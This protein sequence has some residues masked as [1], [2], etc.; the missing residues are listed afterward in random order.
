[1]QAFSTPSAHAY[2]TVRGRPINTRAGNSYD[3]KRGGSLALRSFEVA[4]AAPRI[5]L[6]R[7]NLMIKLRIAFG[8]LA[9]AALLAA[10]GE[11]V[12]PQDQ[13]PKAGSTTS[14]VA[15]APP[16]QPDRNTPPAPPPATHNETPKEPAAAA[17]A[18]TARDTPAQKP[19]S[20][21]TPS[22]ESRSMPKPMQTDNHSTPSGDAARKGSDA[23]AK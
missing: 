8:T 18:P 9:A 21:L 2:N 17:A 15:T 14:N 16:A 12:P 3:A 4:P 23:A 1:V 7:R 22:E 6:Q 13:T 11:P 10:C 19:L 5:H 20:D